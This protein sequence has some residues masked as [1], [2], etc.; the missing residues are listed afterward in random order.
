MQFL[1]CIIKIINFPKLNLIIL[2]KLNLHV[3]DLSILRR[4]SEEKPARTS[5]HY[6]NI[7]IIGI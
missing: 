3:A 4:G 2:I 7:T 1:F 5:K 6:K